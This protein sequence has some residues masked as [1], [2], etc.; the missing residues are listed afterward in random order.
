MA[1]AN[2]LR[3]LKE[4]G[5][6][7]RNPVDLVGVPSMVFRC[8]F[9][10]TG[11]KADDI[12]ALEVNCPNDLCSFWKAAESAKLFEDQTYGQWGLHI[13]SP[14]DAAQETQRLAKERPRDFARGDL[15]TG[16]FLGDSDLL[17]VRCND[18]KSDF[19]RVL[20]A[21][22]LDPRIDWYCAAESFEQFLEKYLEAKGEKYWEK[23]LDD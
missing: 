13:L 23:S 2:I 3:L 17:I 1:I 5:S 6:H 15:V 10:D 11:A 7:I 21:Q 18:N 8:T 16:R 9:S 4:K 22:P 19:G 14:S 12:S 20:V